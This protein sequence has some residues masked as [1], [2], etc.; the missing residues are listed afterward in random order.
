ME[1]INV[2]V[3]MQVRLVKNKNAYENKGFAF[4]AYK[5]I[6]VAQKENKELQ[7]QEYKV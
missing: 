1:L 4:V 2:I 6:D 7:S 3:Y 5:T